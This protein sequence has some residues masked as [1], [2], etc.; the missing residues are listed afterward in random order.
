MD[1]ELTG[2]L[3]HNAVQAPLRNVSERTIW[4]VNDNRA[5]VVWTDKGSA[6]CLYAALAAQ[7]LLRYNALH[8]RR[9][10]KYVTHTHDLPGLVKVMA[11]DAYRLWDLS[12]DALLTRSNTT[13]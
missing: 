4:I 6:T 2:V 12:D 9:Y 5:A 13:S 8:Q 3:A 10:R 11:D 1:L 7:H